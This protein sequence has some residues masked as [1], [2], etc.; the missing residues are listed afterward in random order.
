MKAIISIVLVGI[1]IACIWGGY[2]KG[3]IMGIGGILAII[4][5]LYA[6]NLLAN[7]Y[8]GE[9][10]TALRPFAE[11]F[12]ERC[13]NDDEDGI[14]AKMGWEDSSYSADD[15]LVAYPERSLEYASGCFETLGIASDKAEE[16]GKDALLRQ[17]QDGGTVTENVI[18]VLCETVSYVACF[19]L[20]FI[21]ILIVI[22]V[23]GNIPN[24]SYKIPHLDLLNDI[25]GAVL[26]LATGL[27]F[28][29][30]ICWALKFLGLIVGQD[31]LSGGIIAFFGKIHILDS[32][33]GI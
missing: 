7:T 19:C 8:S 21:I 2:K 3:M 4:V 6:A 27:L 1:I 18:T 16:L 30:I 24:F 10:I 33:M 12:T 13:M 5:S 14:M 31:T 22:T 11:G 23:I 15:L 9:I 29:I 26:G 25:A 32:L 28:C 17:A 20:A